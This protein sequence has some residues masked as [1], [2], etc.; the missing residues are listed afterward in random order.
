[1]SE[2]RRPTGATDH[3]R[4]PT[5]TS[6]RPQVSPG[7]GLERFRGRGDPCGR[8]GVPILSSV[9]RSLHLLDFFVKGI[10]SIANGA[11]VRISFRGSTSRR[12][13]SREDDSSRIHFAWGDD[14]ANKEIFRDLIHDAFA[15]LYN[16]DPKYKKKIHPD[17]QTQLNMYAK[18][19]LDNCMHTYLLSVWT[20]RNHKL[21]DYDEN[22]I[23]D[24]RLWPSKFAGIGFRH[25]GHPMALATE[26]D[27]NGRL[28]LDLLRRP[29]QAV[30]SK[31]PNTRRYLP[32]LVFQ[33]RESDV[34][35]PGRS[36]TTMVQRSAAPMK[37]SS[38]IHRFDVRSKKD[39]WEKDFLEVLNTV[40]EQRPGLFSKFLDRL[41]AL[42]FA[43]PN[44]RL[45]DAGDIHLRQRVNLDEIKILDKNLIKDIRHLSKGER[46]MLILHSKIIFY[47]GSANIFIL[48]LD[49]LCFSPELSDKFIGNVFQ[50]SLNRHSP[51]FIISS[52]DYS[53]GMAFAKQYDDERV[54]K[55]TA[56]FQFNS[57]PKSWRVPK[58]GLCDPDDGFDTRVRIAVEGPKDKLFYD[59]VLGPRLGGKVVFIVPSE[60]PSLKAKRNGCLG[61]KQY[62]D[63]K[64]TNGVTVDASLYYGICDGESSAALKEMDHFVSSKDL[65]IRSKKHCSS[66][67]IY[68]N[69]YELENILIMQGLVDLM[70]RSAARLQSN[71]QLE[72]ILREKYWQT[73]H[74]MA[75]LAARSDHYYRRDFK[76]SL[77]FASA[78]DEQIVNHIIHL[79][80]V[81][82]RQFHPA[83]CRKFK[84]LL[85][86]RD[87]FMRSYP[88]VEQINDLSSEFFRFSNGKDVLEVL[89]NKLNF[90][91]TSKIRRKSEFEALLI[92]S[93]AASAFADT[94][95]TQLR[96]MLI[97]DGH[98]FLDVP[99]QETRIFGVKQDQHLRSDFKLVAHAATMASPPC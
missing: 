7:S 20:G 55:S 81:S 3:T 2:C 47:R 11:R 90:D 84:S 78:T 17:V 73:M 89:R 51:Q 99:A 96:R 95:A 91:G 53:I 92:E 38:A 24:F 27:A 85:S 23:D 25:L 70:K 22:E 6:A 29:T 59:K 33:K 40:F 10:P 9:F 45:V 18:C 54:T 72:N 79:E 50:F 74:S 75:A 16:S 5:A 94:M 77:D 26:T 62:I 35:F 71:V 31:R 21:Y 8:L 67:L 88:A 14:P 49:A 64:R 80:L 66:R 42:S 12:F 13:G 98:V 83:F 87:C 97:E 60:Q 1:M 19:Q 61:V 37:T 44:R 58:N 56:E 93:V 4:L 41:N 36:D 28:I 46:E 65:L 39:A 52:N 15:H 30:G 43:R 82:Y 57:I 68:L 63:H 32:T 48:D 34:L 86:N 69:C 76:Y